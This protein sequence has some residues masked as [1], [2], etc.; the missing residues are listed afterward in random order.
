VRNE[1]P[2]AENYVVS[3][4]SPNQA[5][6]RKAPILEGRSGRPHL[7]RSPKALLYSKGE[8]GS[9][10]PFA[11]PNS[12][13]PSSLRPGFKNVRRGARKMNGGEEDA[14]DGIS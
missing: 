13:P 8:K 11:D 12:D 2:P 4:E 9:E 6:P 3:S 7:P 14:Y 5:A 1:S 10:N